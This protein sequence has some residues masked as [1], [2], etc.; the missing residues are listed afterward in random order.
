MRALITGTSGFVA[1]HVVEH[2]LRNTDWEIVGL[3]KLGAASEGY[4]RLRDI[5]AFDDKRVTLLSH[6]VS[7]QFTV[8]LLKEIGRVE[9][10]IHMAAESHVDRSILFPM[11]F[12]VANTIGT[13]QMLSMA[14]ECSG[15]RRFVYF[16]TDEVFGPAPEGVYYKEW[17]R[18]KASNPYAA[19]KAAGECYVDAYVNT[20]KLPAFTTH[21][22]NIFGERQHGEK[23]V[24]MCIR[25]AMRR[26]KVYIH[27][28]PTRTISGSRCWIHARNVAAA[29]MFLL[30]NSEVGE[31]YNIVGEELTNLEIAQIVARTVG[32]P[33]LYEMVDFH[34]SRPGHDLR[35][36]LDGTRLE[37]M[38]WTYPRTLVESLEKT[39]RWSMER[40]RWL[41]LEAA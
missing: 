14:R 5:E 10:I 32:K 22:M 21:S 37:S 12:A 34:T 6:D 8:G 30:H 40:P 23:F 7:Q 33:L 17:D 35:Y 38:G 41:G 27:S 29:L 11:E 3:D 19:S 13:V 24:P 20:Y 15:L 28:D 31:R 1:H 36:A 26:E 4:D 9:Y 39:V 2:I 18:F 25:K 16:S